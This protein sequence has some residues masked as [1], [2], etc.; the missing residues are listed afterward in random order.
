MKPRPILATEKAIR[1]LS[2]MCGDH[3][4]RYLFSTLCQDP[5]TGSLQYTLP[6]SASESGFMAMEFKCMGWKPLYTIR[7][8]LK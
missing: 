2:A 1:T 5:E 4:P 8:M 3:K 6:A 7:I